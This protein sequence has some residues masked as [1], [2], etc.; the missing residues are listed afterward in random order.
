MRAQ[1]V[2]GDSVPFRFLNEKSTR[3]IF[4]VRATAPS[5]RFMPTHLFTVA[6]ALF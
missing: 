6:R 2:P 3:A 5:V 4:G 1:R